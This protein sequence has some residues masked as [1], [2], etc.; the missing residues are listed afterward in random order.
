VSNS[1]AQSTSNWYGIIQIAKNPGGEAEKLYDTSCGTYATSVNVS[2]SVS[3][4]IGTYSMTFIKSG[5]SQATLLMFA[6]PHHVQSFSSKTKSCL[7]SVKL[8]TTTKGTAMAVV[9]DSWILVEPDMPIHMH[10]APWNPASGNMSRLSASAIAAIQNAAISELSQ[11]MSQQTN[12]NSFYY[13]GKVGKV[14]II[15]YIKLMLKL[16]L[17]QSLLESYT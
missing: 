16:R 11:D 13:A 4:A 14:M 2:G 1:L 15:C 3:G 9:A 7:S 5:L 6:L 12:L 17:L 10:F 8:Q